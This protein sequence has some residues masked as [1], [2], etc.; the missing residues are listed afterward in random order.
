[1]ALMRRLLFTQIV[2]FCTLA[3]VTQGQTQNR[4]ELKQIDTS[5]RENQQRLEQSRTK[6]GEVLLEIE[7][8]EKQVAE[9]SLRYEQTQ[10]KTAK[11]ETRAGLLE[12]ERD[13]TSREYVQA[14]QKLAKLIESAYLMGH[15]SALKVALSQNGTQNMARLG[16]YMRSIS[17]ARQNHLDTLHSLQQQLASKDEALTRERSQLDKLRTALEKDQRYLGQLKRNRLAMIKQLDQ[18][19]ES[20]AEEIDHLRTRRKKLEKLLADIARRKQEEARKRTQEHRLPPLGIPSAGRKITLSPLT[21]GSLPL[22]ADA[23]IVSHFGD[24]RPR[25]G[26]PWTGI[27][28]EGKEGSDVRAISAGEVVY[29]DWLPGYGQM[30]IIDH[31]GGIMSLYG[32]NNRIYRSVGEQVKQSDVI[33]AMGKTAGLKKPALYFEIRQNGKARDPMIWF[34]G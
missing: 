7:S 20:S 4:H 1:M 17:A 6:R 25:S 31:G 29:A 9:R 24:K 12:K 30:V 2:I 13:K 33:A 15:Q 27:F 10:A 22:P 28:M 18:T 19:I 26:L 34:R 16:H 5:L 11:L 14:K 3:S 8:L 21:A 23:V 32:H